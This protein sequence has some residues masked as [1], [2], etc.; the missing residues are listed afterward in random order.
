MM[1][2]RVDV[3]HENYLRRSPLIRGTAQVGFGR[4]RALDAARERRIF[5]EDDSPVR[6][7]L[8][9]Q[10]DSGFF[11]LPRKQLDRASSELARRA[12]ERP[13]AGLQEVQQLVV[14]L[15]AFVSDGDPSEAVIDGGVSH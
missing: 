15:F 5:E 6:A 7:N 10:A 4:H 14:G 2:T 8:V 3:L 9:A 1:R 12:I 13:A 11:T